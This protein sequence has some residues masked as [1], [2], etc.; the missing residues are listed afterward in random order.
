MTDS[1]S[2]SPDTQRAGESQRLLAGSAQPSLV[3][4]ACAVLVDICAVV[5]VA[6]PVALLAAAAPWLAVIPALLILG[7]QIAAVTVTG[8]TL[9]M[10]AVGTRIVSRTDGLA[11]RLSLFAGAAVS[12]HARS[13]LA[14]VDIRRGHDP[15]DAPPPPAS[16]SRSTAAPPRAV[17]S[18]I[19]P[20]PRLRIDD[21]TTVALSE[22]IIIGRDPR[23]LDDRGRRLVGITDL[24]R[25][26]SKTHALLEPRD[27]AVIVTDLGSTNGVMLM[28][29][30]GITEITPWVPTEV[31]PGSLI[32]LGDRRFS[33]TTHTSREV[34]YA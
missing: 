29:P 20:I 24:S 26:M 27:G 4:H 9:G 30:T 25:S 19:R 6:L 10:A 1:R 22:P 16:G 3:K 12:R 8:R 28:S 31:A 15:F 13:G 11:P 23:D 17:E 18:T 14:I 34:S 5:A 33:L 32:R 2:G 21:G 7:I